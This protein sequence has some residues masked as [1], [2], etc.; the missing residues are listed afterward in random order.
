MLCY[1]GNKRFSKLQDLVDDTL[2]T[3]FML[4]RQDEVSQCISQGREEQRRCT[5][6]RR[7]K[8]RKVLRRNRG[9]RLVAFVLGRRGGEGGKYDMP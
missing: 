5:W 1:P 4:Q 9:R 8:R 6:N 3:Q 2:I 7:G